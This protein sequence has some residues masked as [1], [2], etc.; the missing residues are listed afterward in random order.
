MTLRGNRPG[1]YIT[2]YTLVYKEYPRARDESPARDYHEGHWQV[3][4]F[5]QQ[6]LSLT[7][8]LTHTLSL[9]LSLS[10]CRGRGSGRGETWRHSAFLAATTRYKIP[11]REAGPPNHH[12]DK[13]D[14]GQ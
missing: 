3:P 14:S 7:L 12:D 4:F 13:V 11:W 2:E 8:T 6:Y 9:P 10:L 5:C 1:S